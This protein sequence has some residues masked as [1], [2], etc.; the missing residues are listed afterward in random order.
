MLTSDLLFKSLIKNPYT[1]SKLDELFQD[2]DFYYLYKHTRIDPNQY[3]F[4]IFKKCQLKFSKP[5]DFN[6]PYDCHFEIKVNFSGLTRNR[7][8]SENNLTILEHEWKKSKETYKK[9]LTEIIKKS[10]LEDFR[11]KYFTISCFNNSPLNILMWSHYAD[12]HKGFLIEF[13]FPKKNLGRFPLPVEYCSEYPIITIP[14]SLQIYRSNLNLQIEQAKKTFY[15]K[16]KEWIYENEYRLINNQNELATFPAEYI[17]SVIF[18][19]NTTTPIK[20]TIKN[21]IEEFNL[22]NNLNVKTYESQLAKRKFK[23]VVPNHPRLNN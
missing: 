22:K 9:T 18:G 13:K 3:V 19:T 8:N 4:N 10:A 20:N 1:L 16:S 2:D 14:A 15:I 17:S 6:D 21:I 7:F 5:A 23:I 11:N 12:N